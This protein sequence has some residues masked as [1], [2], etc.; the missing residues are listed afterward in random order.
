MPFQKGNKESKGRPKGSKNIR[1][2]NAEE[3]ASRMDVDP[4][5]I[6]IHFATGNYKA[7][8][9]EN[10]CYF[11]E[12]PS[13]EIKM[14]YVISPELRASS[15]EKACRYLYSQKQAVALTAGADTGIKIE[16]VDYS[17]K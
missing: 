16:I 17:K 7:L 8:G 12:G 9:Y 10:E 2:F 14:G 4:L 1:T 3:L 13:G 5:E 15:A 11:K 6:L